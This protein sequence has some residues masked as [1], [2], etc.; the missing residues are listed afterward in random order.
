MRTDMFEPF[1]VNFTTGHSARRD[2][3]LALRLIAP[4]GE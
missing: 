2:G 1:S 3:A 4:C